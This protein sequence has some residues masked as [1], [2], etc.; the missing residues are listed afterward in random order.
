MQERGERSPRIDSNESC[1]LLD[2]QDINFA[3]FGDEVTRRL[4]ALCDRAFDSV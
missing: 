2:G 3:S 1:R 4:D